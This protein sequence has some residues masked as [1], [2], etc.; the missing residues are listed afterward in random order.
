MCIRDRLLPTLGWNVY[1]AARYHHR[2]RGAGDRRLAVGADIRV[3]LTSAQYFS[4]RDPV[5][6][7]ALR[8]L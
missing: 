7:R 1:I 2:K 4:G 6:E 3:D 8:G 5:L